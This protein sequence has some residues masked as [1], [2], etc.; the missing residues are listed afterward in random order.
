LVHLWRRKRS[1]PGADVGTRSSSIKAWLVPIGRLAAD[2]FVLSA[3]GG[4]SRGRDQGVSRL[5]PPRDAIRRTRRGQRENAAP[6]DKATP[7]G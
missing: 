3:A 4:F 1:L 2:A 7:R 5:P 6:P